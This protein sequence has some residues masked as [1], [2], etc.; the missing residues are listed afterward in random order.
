MP[1][2]AHVL[3]IDQGTTN[4]KV[5]LL[6]EAG[7]VVAQAQRQVSV[8]HPRPGWAE[9]DADALWASVRDATVDCLRKVGGSAPQAIGI[10]NQRESVVVW[11]R[12]SGQPVAPCI[13]WQCA[14]TADRLD[15]LRG[16]GHAGTVA[17]RTGLTLDPM[18][19][20]AKIAWLLDETPGAREAARAGHLAAGTVDSWLL[21]KLTQGRVHA[22]DTS[23][24]SRTQL[25]D[26]GTCRWDAGLCDLFGVPR[27]ILP[28]VRPSDALF[29]HA[30]AI[31]EL[32]SVPVHAMLGDSHAALFGHGIRSPGAA[33][34]TYGTGS[35][36]MTLTDGARASRHG[37]STTIGWNRNGA[38]AYALEGN[39][40]VSGQAL[41]FVAQ[42]LGLP[43]PAEVGTL[44]TTVADSG[45]VVF[46]PAL[47]GLGA[48]WWDASARGLF[49]GL[50]HATKP[51]HLAR[52]AMEAVTLQIADVFRAMEADLGTAIDV[53]SVDGGASSNNALMQLQ[54][55]VLGRPVRRAPQA[56]QSACGAGLMAGFAAGVF[57]EDV[58]RRACEKDRRVFL[59]TTDDHWRGALVKAWAD[60]VARATMS[61]PGP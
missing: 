43:G 13:L 59:P 45:G 48:P 1:A 8:S 21:W 15:V 24:A 56:E 16:Q 50:S 10:S 7:A 12:R 60:A 57:D 26:I 11:D 41:A 54:A 33:K 55:D 17:R 42:L 5:V 38:V 4:T 36:L 49:C 47:A 46:V 39:I 27:S 32:R 44:A 51:A 14:R 34:V 40:I 28:E 9:Q 25:F 19:P 53:L 35:S 3:A 6:D 58:A 22:C 52:A 23:N 61:A 18:F 29:G 37:L 30:D 20:A 2:R 31:P